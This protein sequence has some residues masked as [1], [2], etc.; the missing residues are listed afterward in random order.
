MASQKRFELPT[1]SLGNCCSILLSYWDTLK[2]AIYG[3]MYRIKK[4][5]PHSLL[6]QYP[7][8]VKTLISRSYVMIMASQER[9]ELPTDA[10]EGRC[11]IQLSYWDVC[12]SLFVFQGQYLLYSHS[13]NKSTDFQKKFYFIFKL[14]FLYLNI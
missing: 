7:L 14:C 5:I 8:L 10:L 2:I 11:S 6:C 3:I 9:F 13:I 12:V 1:Y 4:E